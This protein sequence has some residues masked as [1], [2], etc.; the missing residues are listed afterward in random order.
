MSI[1]QVDQIRRNA[2]LSRVVRRTAE[3]ELVRMWLALKAA[4][5]NF[6]P[7][8]P[9]AGQADIIMASWRSE[10]A[11]SPG[12]ENTIMD[13]CDEIAILSLARASLASGQADQA[14]VLLEPINRSAQAAGH[15]YAAIGSLILTAIAWQAKPAG[16]GSAL[17]A[18]EQALSLA[19]PGGY[20]RV[21]VDEGQP[22]QKLL[23]LAVQKGIHPGYADRLLAA[24]DHNSTL[25]PSPQA[26]QK[27]TPALIEP[28]TSREIEVLRLIVAG[29]TNKE[30]AQKLYISL[31]TVKYHT[32][33]I[34]NKLNVNNR[35]HAAARARELGLL[36]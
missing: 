10:L 15:I 2:Q 28:L 25:S 17:T 9:L 22:I 19:E 34:L 21:F 13:E 27:H 5:V 26:G 35:A 11:H 36:N 29:M 24:F 20:V 6:V 12:S 18:L 14:L 32:T 4:G 1:D 31:R 33:S 16:L 7:G 30:I 23:A 8:D 3:A